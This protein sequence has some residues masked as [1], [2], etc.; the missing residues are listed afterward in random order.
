LRAVWKAAEAGQGPFDRL[1][2]FLLLTAARRTE[3][4]SMTWAE[5]DGTDWT[6]PAARNKAKVDLVRPLSGA[7]LALLETRP[8]TCRF[9]FTTDDE[10]PISGFSKF[11]SQFDK[12]CGVV[13]WSPHDLRRTA[14]SLMSRAGV[15]SD[16][17][18]RCLGHIIGGVRGVYDRHEYYEEK[19]R[20]FE[21]L[22][23][24]V[25]QILNP[26]PNVTQISRARG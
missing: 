4:A 19:A 21:A 12:A 3:A 7:A 13:D 9:V 16:H 11:K 5:L 10:H 8:R 26:A 1:V 23:S 14:R 20:A 6:L 15:N 22:A 25:Q 24:I 17:A 2:Q 18:E